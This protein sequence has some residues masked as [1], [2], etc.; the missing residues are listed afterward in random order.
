ML[1]RIAVLKPSKLNQKSLLLQPQILMGMLR[2]GH[3]NGL[4]QSEAE[5]IPGAIYTLS[6]WYTKRELAK[7]VV[8]F[9]FGMVGC[10]AICSL[11][12]SGILKLIGY[13]W[14]KCCQRSFLRKWYHAP[15][16]SQ[17]YSGKTK[18]RTH[19]HHARVSISPLSLPRFL[20]VI[21]ASA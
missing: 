9:F 3:K 14:M 16:P 4:G 21:P 2:S 6:T 10:S 20:I 15:F 1:L 11:L 17:T 8:I 5:Y 19:L 13:R 7:R 12:A 18:S